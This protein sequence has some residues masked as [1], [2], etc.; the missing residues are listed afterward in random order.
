MLIL[1][2]LILQV[3]LHDCA[4]NFRRQKTFADMQ[5]Q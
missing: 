5:G 3:Y 2:K 4:K 1:T